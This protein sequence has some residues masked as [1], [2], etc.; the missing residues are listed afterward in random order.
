MLLDKPLTNSQIELLKAFSHDLSEDDL[1]ALRRMLARF[2]ADRASDEVDRLWGERG[3]TEDTMHK[4][5]RGEEPS[6]PTK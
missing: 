1:L 4:I 6:Q 2:F 3:W 5:I